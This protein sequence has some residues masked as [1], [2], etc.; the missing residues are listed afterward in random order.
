MKKNFR[1]QKILEYRERIVDLEKNKLA[2][3]NGKLTNTNNK[4]K[5]TDTEITKQVDDRQ[6][7]ENMFK[8]MYDKY[9]KKLTYEKTELIKLKKQLELNIELQKK[10]VMEAIERHKIMQKLKDQHVENYRMFLNKEE[11]K[12]IDELAVTRSAR[13]ED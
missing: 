2:E 3:I 6:T 4:I 9:I 7:A 8:I 13:N 10:K 11:M 12:M 1:L 5:T